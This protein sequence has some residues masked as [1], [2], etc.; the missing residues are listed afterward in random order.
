MARNI[1]P[2]IFGIKR[3]GQ[4]LASTLNAEEKNGWTAATHLL[5]A[6]Q[7]EAPYVKG[8]NLQRSHWIRCG[9][10]PAEIQGTTPRNLLDPLAHMKYVEPLQRV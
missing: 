9:P 8:L 4:F 7:V 1:S 6:S 5:G 3:P 10:C 2:L